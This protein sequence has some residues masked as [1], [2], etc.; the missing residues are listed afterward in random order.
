MQLV[1]PS[2]VASADRMLIAVWMMNFQSSFFF[3]VV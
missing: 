2:A 3:I 1:T